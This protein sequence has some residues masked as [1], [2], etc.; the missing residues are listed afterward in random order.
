MLDLKHPIQS[1]PQLWN[2][3]FQEGKQHGFVFINKDKVAIRT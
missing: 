3:P 2:Q 1:I